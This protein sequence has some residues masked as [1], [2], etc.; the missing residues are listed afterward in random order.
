MLL[1]T[2]GNSIAQQDTLVAE[3]PSGKYFRTE[4]LRATML[5]VALPGLGQIYNRKYWKVPLVYA[6]FAGVIYAIDFNTS[7]YNTFLKAYQD[8]TDAF[9]ETKSYLDLEGLQGIDPSDFDPIKNPSGY[10]WYKDRILRMVDYHRKYRDLSYIGIAAWYLITI[11]DANVDASLSDYD[12]SD[13][14]DLE[15]GPV[16]MPIM[17]Q[18]PSGVSLTMRV[19]F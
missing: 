2:T 12:I 15:I 14:L 11:L 18:L 3:K 5:A 8:L 9:P 13:N 4:P 19:T 6:G 17:G 10:S 1:L 16:T 7:R